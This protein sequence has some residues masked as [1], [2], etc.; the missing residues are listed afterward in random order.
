MVGDEGGMV[1]ARFRSLPQ[2]THAGYSISGAGSNWGMREMSVRTR[3]CGAGAGVR[4]RSRRSHHR[5]SLLGRLARWPASLAL[6]SRTLRRHRSMY[7]HRSGGLKP[8]TASA[9]ASG[10]ASIL[11]G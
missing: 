10:E 5:A 7:L 6:S 2:R 1:P 11:S 4:F 9:I 3:P 8:S